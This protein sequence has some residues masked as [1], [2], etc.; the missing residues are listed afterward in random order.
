MKIIHMKLLQ[1]GGEGIGVEQAHQIG[2][3]YAVHPVLIAWMNSS[4]IRSLTGV[5]HV[6]IP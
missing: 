1:N 2:Q 6:A 5:I 4:F 3:E